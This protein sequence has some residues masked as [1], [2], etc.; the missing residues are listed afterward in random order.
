MN[1]PV[2]M[3]FASTAHKVQ[4]ITIKR[5]DL[6]VVDPKRARTCKSFC[7]LKQSKGPLDFYPEFSVSV[8]D[9]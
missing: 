2:K 5:P 8:K 4:G 1:F 7:D 6:L 3:G 9:D